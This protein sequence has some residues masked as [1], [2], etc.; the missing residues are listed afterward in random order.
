MINQL[1]KS[2]STKN[3]PHLVSFHLQHLKI[4]FGK[5]FDKML[6]FLPFR[7]LYRDWDQCVRAIREDFFA[8]MFTM[9]GYTYHYLKTKRGAKSPDFLVEYGNERGVIEI[10]N[11]HPCWDSSHDLRAS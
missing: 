9:K 6:M 5:Q 10:E 4:I 2:R 3:I 11:H 7:L 1:F 8:E